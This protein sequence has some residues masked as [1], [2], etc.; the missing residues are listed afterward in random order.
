MS[1]LGTVNKT[2]AAQTNITERSIREYLLSGAKVLFESNGSEMVYKID[3]VDG[4]EISPRGFINDRGNIKYPKAS[5]DTVYIGHR[6]GWSSLNI[7]YRTLITLLNGY[8]PSGGH[9]IDC[10]DKELGFTPENIILL[11]KFSKT[12]VPL[13]VL[14]RT[15]TIQ[16][17]FKLDTSEKIN[18][19]D[20]YTTK[21]QV[22]EYVT[23]DFAVFPTRELAEWHQKNVSEAKGYAQVVLDYNGGYMIAEKVFQEKVIYNKA[24]PYVHFREVMDNNS[25]VTE[26][27]SK[28]VVQFNNFEIGGEPKFAYLFSGKS[29]TQEV[30][31]EIVDMLTLAREVFEN[32]EG[33]SKKSV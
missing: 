5:N 15:G 26:R 4:L 10:K 1:N 8:I 21:T 30:A 18:H 29:Y 7:A 23:E 3:G 6:T 25:G 9:V 13:D 17:E 28:E 11:D 20:L 33:L 24:K 27:V 14:Q 31:D 19:E 22:K 32:L 12:P 16:A 2:I